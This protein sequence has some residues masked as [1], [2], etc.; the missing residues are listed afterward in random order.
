LAHALRELLRLAAG[1]VAPEHPDDRCAFEPGRVQRLLWALHGGKAGVAQAPALG[2]RL[3]RRPVGESLS[4]DPDEPPRPRTYGFPVVPRPALPVQDGQDGPGRYRI[5]GVDCDTGE[6]VEL[7]VDALTMANAKVKAE[8]KGVIVTQI[9]KDVETGAGP[10]D[11]R[12]G[13][14]E[15]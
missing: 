4:I 9:R 6:D 5:V 7:H 13:G 3:V 15:A 1:E 10:H 2:E 14:T 11:P 12:D 8:L